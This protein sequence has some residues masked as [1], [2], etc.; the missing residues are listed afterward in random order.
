M[1]E[2][3]S[4]LEIEDLDERHQLRIRTL[5]E[6]LR[7]K[8][9]VLKALDEEILKTCPTKEIEQEIEEAEDIN[10]KIVAI[11]AEIDSWGCVETSEGR[12][13]EPRGESVM[14][15][16]SKDNNQIVNNVSHEGLTQVNKT[17][18]SAVTRSDFNGEHEML[19]M[20]TF[21]T[22]PKLL[23]IVLPKFNGEIT[24]FQA[25][26]DSF[27]SAINRNPNL[28]EVDKFNDLTALLEGTAACSIQ[29]LPPSEAN[30]HAATEILMERFGKKQ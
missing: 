9:G 23:Q 4:L 17:G 18:A 30:Y 16:V 29:G 8:S 7:E 20:S 2:A 25:F 12:I 10:A 22:K 21:T 27:E 5:S 26:W 6:L 3:K 24:K 15:M 19:D 28:S 1:Q 11:S 13:G 14:H